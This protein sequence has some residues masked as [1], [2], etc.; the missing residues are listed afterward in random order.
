MICSKEFP[1]WEFFAGTAR[2]VRSRARDPVA[3]PKD[4]GAATS[5]GASGREKTLLR[6]SALGRAL[7][8][9]LSQ[10]CFSPHPSPFRENPPHPS[11]RAKLATG[12]AKRMADLLHNPATGLRRQKPTLTI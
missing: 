6:P 5:N 2:P 11:S 9:P 4:R 1:R 7:G 12:Q 10:N 8:T 3:S